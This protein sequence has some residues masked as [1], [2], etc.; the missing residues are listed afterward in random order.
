MLGSPVAFPRVE[1]VFPIGVRMN[2]DSRGKARAA[3]AEGKATKAYRPNLALMSAGT[4]SMFTMMSK[5][6]ARKNGTDM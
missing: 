6:L 4:A 2:L 3:S 5:V 1:P